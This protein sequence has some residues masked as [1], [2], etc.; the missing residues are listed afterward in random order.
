MSTQE[1]YAPIHIFNKL[2]AKLAKLQKKLAK[3]EKF[4]NRWRR[5]KSQITK[6]HIRIANTRKDYLHKLSRKLSKN[7]AIVILEDLKINNMSKSAKGDVENPGKNVKQKSGLN[8]AILDQGWG[9]FL[10][11]LE[12]KLTW[13]GGQL[14]R[15]N[16]RNT[17]RKCPKCGYI[18]AENRKTQA[19]FC[20][21]QKDCQYTANADYVGSLNIR[22]AGLALL[23]LG[24]CSNEHSL[25]SQPT[26]GV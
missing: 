4:S 14:V 8:R 15:V 18:S 23:G 2:K 10:G 13:N 5:L 25:K 22:E 3:K 26:D 9:E 1:Y 7:H 16:H 19:T 24:E 11:Q 17:S 12:Y 6:L 20:C 21:Q